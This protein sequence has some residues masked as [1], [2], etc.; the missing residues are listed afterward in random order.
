VVLAPS[1]TPATTAR[2]A[3]T[4]DYRRP[5]CIQLPNK[6]TGMV[7]FFIREVNHTSRVASF[8]RQ[9][10]FIWLRPEGWKDSWMNTI[11]GSD[12]VPAG[13]AKTFWTEFGADPTEDR[14]Q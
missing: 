8:G 5:A 12:K 14:R 4:I 3:V 2:P 13:R 7:R 1:A 6:G 10:R 11:T 9:I